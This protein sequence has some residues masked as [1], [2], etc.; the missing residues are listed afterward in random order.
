L[1]LLKPILSDDN[2]LTFVSINIGKYK[3]LFTVNFRKH[4]NHGKRPFTQ[5]HS[6]YLSEKEA[7]IKLAGFVRELD[8]KSIQAAC[9]AIAHNV[10]RYEKLPIAGDF[11]SS[12]TK[13]EPG[14]NP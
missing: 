3:L 11:L 8:Q 7:T 14:Y 5:Y 6:E 12:Y 10:R 4:Y 2:E 1:R 9:N 13:V